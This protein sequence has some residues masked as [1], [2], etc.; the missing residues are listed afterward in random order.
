MHVGNRVIY[1][2]RPQKSTKKRRW[3][4][5]QTFLINAKLNLEIEVNKR[6]DW[7]KSLKETKVRI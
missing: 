5:V 1:D 6:A 3:N 2:L 7:E 4:C